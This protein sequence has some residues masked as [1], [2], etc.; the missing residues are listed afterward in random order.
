VIVLGDGTAVGKTH[1]TCSAARTL[2]QSHRVLALKPLETGIRPHPDGGPPSGSDAA[3]LEG[4]SDAEHR[5]R[6][7]PLYAF[8][9]AVSPHLAA[10]WAKREVE[11]SSLVAWVHAAELRAAV[12]VSLVETAGGA[13]SPISMFSKN[14]DLARDLDPAV[15]VLVAHNS[16]GVLHRVT[17][18]VEALT[19]R[20]RAPD[21]V[22]LSD[23]ASLDP[24]G[25]DNLAELARL[26]DPPVWRH[27][28][29]ATKLVPALRDALLANLSHS[30]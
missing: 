17:A 20:G 30:P 25:V 7:H 4:A 12:D 11:L 28:R 3:L 6:P 16:L 22:V 27:E 18:T 8:E 5:P 29:G 10:R 13:F 26:I 14:L 23:G 15:W 24:S 21:H 1:F 19:A 2:A 9:P